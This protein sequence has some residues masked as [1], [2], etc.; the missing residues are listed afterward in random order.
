MATPHDAFLL[1]SLANVTLT[2]SSGSQTGH[3]GLQCVTIGENVF[4]VVQMGPTEVVL[5]PTRT[6]NLILSDSGNRT[7]KFDPTDAEPNELTIAVVPPKSP[8]PAYLEDLEIFESILAQYT[9]LKGAPE[10]VGAAVPAT[11]AAPGLD[12]SSIS[13][14]NV[15]LAG[16]SDLRGHLV[17]VNQD[18]GNIV[19]EFDQKIHVQEDPILSTKGHENDPVVIEIPEDV[20]TSGNAREVFARSIPPEHRGVLAGSATLIRCV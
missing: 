8:D 11:T 2:T 3:L 1:L 15:N 13:S 4:L 17:L 10:I 6:A 9:E 18:N 5:D 16:G 7:Y 20:A 19:G 14:P 12:L